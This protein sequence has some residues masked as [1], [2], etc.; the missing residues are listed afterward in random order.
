MEWVNMPP[1]IHIVKL[2]THES[3]QPLKICETSQGYRY[4]N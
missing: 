1:R 3:Y 2:K 4:K